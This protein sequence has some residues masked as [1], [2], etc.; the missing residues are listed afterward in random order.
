MMNKTSDDKVS[1][2]LP[3][4]RSSGVQNLNNKTCYKSANNLSNAVTSCLSPFS[5]PSSS[6]WAQYGVM[7]TSSRCGKL[8]DI[9]NSDI[10]HEGYAK[11]SSKVNK[12]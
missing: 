9:S 10:V 11:V 6:K 1:T 12:S 8:K 4:Q 3:S 5:D 7:A 2:T